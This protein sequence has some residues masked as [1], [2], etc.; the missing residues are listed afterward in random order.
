MEPEYNNKL[1]S[2]LDDVIRGESSSRYGKKRNL[3]YVMLFFFYE[4]FKRIF[5]TL[6]KL[7]ILQKKNI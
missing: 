4:C 1:N 2:R 7:R 5:K 3:F 6:K